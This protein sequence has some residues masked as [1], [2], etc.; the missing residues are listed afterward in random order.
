MLRYVKLRYYTI[1]LYYT[2]LHYIILYHVNL[3]K[4]TQTQIEKYNKCT[5]NEIVLTSTQY[6]I[7]FLLPADYK[8]LIRR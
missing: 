6:S 2:T 7:E 1:L 5:I 3:T 8:K 4:G